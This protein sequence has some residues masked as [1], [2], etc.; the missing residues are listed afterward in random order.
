MKSVIRSCLIGRVIY[1]RLGDL[2]LQLPFKRSHVTRIERGERGPDYAL[3]GWEV[4]WFCIRCGIG[5]PF[6]VGVV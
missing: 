3:D 1:G 4:L 5:T 6:H 2:I